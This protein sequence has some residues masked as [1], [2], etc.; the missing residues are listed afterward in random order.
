M[1]ARRF[2]PLRTAPAATISRLISAT[3]TP[4][5]RPVS[6]RFLPR[7]FPHQEAHMNNTLLIVEGIIIV[8]ILMLVGYVMYSLNLFTK[9]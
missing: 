5:G 3:I 9:E 1:G 6:S 8:A 4:R 7:T 2:T